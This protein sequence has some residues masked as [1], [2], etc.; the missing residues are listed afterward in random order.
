MTSFHTRGQPLSAEWENAADEKA[1]VPS[2]GLRI[3]SSTLSLQS[4]QRRDTSSGR[5]KQS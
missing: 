2:T 5:L 1:V 4:E 3:Q